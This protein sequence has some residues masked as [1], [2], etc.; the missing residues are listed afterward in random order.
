MKRKFQLISIT[1]IL[2]FSSVLISC[3]TN[4]SNSDTA[5][6]NETESV[7]C[8]ET[9]EETIDAET[10]ALY[11]SLGYENN[12]VIPASEG[13]Y[14]YSPEWR[15]TL[16]DNFSYFD[17]A[18][19]LVIAEFMQDFAK[20]VYENKMD[21]ETVY[22]RMTELSKDGFLYTP[23]VKEEPQK[24]NNSNKEGKEDK[25]NG[26]SQQQN[27]NNN[28]SSSQEQQPAP[29][30]QTPPASAVEN[31]DDFYSPDVDLTGGM[32]AEE[33]QDNFQY[34]DMEYIRH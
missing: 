2:L 19:Q 1:T 11:D 25:D 22:Y 12:N 28:N 20:E 24:E 9:Q 30:E 3:S 33:A 7:I 6:K 29:E 34:P 15:Q 17:G 23:P 26:G 4:T 31:G 8:T 14:L 18:P 21:G 10:Q 16:E 13:G 5:Q 27:N 32:T